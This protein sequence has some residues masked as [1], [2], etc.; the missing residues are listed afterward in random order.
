MIQL[1]DQVAIVNQAIK[2]LPMKKPQ[3]DALVAAAT[4]LQKLEALQAKL[5][6]VWPDTEKSDEIAADLLDI[7]GVEA[8]PVVSVYGDGKHAQVPQG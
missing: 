3:R 8:S 4:T 2:R 7:L 5:L 6:K 1:S